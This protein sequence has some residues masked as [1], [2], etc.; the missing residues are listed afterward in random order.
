MYFSLGWGEEEVER[1]WDREGEARG[2]SLY[3][4]AGVRM[5]VCACVGCREE[6][7]QSEICN[8]LLNQVAY[9]CTVSCITL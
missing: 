3:V 2:A 5:C 1:E 9:C 7:R 4:C 6:E 8:A